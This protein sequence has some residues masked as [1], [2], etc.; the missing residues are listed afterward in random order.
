M[1]DHCQFCG[2]KISILSDSG[3]WCF[4]CLN[5]NEERSD[6]IDRNL[7]PDECYYDKGYIGRRKKE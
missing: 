6:W 5:C 3:C 1:K 7:H 2:E 4:Y